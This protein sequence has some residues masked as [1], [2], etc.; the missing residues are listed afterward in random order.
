MEQK[1]LHKVHDAEQL[2]VG[3]K[4]EGDGPPKVMVGVQHP[5]GDWLVYGADAE[6]AREIAESL[7]QGAD[8][9][10]GKVEAP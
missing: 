7:M 5:E 4:P 6:R 8:I 3:L 2:I 1:T 9:A 10:E